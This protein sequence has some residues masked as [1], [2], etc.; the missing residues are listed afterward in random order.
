MKEN[1]ATK[2]QQKELVI[3]R[4]FNAPRDE[5]WKAWTE[6]KRVKKWWGPKDYTAPSVKMDFHEGGK[7]LVAMRG[8]DGKDNWS[9]GTYKEIVPLEKI[10]STDSFSDEKGNV[11]PASYYGLTGDFA[12]E[13]TVRITFEDAAG[14]TKMTLR[15]KGISPEMM[16]GATMGWNQSL[17][18]LAKS[19][20]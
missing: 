16:E 18:K 14:G 17:D 11:V 10:V 9:T 2:T 3:T 15:Y 5:V 4:V 12:L 19:L 8:P 6:P 7:Y 20:E 1:Q 13:S